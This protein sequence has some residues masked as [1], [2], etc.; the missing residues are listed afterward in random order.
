[1]LKKTKHYFKELIFFTIFITIFANGVSL[2][3]AQELNKSKLAL[4]TQKLI[5]NTL[6]SPNSNKCQ[7]QR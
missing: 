1:M 6:Y 3:K 2:Y 7:V 4:E 5:N